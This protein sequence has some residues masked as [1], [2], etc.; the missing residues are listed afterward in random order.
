MWP[1]G[2]GNKTSN[3]MSSPIYLN[4]LFFAVLPLKTENFMLYRLLTPL[5]LNY[6]L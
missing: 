6:D 1:K 5:S 4:V 3:Q 2:T